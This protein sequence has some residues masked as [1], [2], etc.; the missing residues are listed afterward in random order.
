MQP[1]RVGMYADSLWMLADHLRTAKEAVQRDTARLY[2]ERSRA[3]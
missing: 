3:Q 2:Q 1:E